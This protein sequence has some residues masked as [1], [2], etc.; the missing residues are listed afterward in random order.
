MKI[1]GEM[2]CKTG[3]ITPSPNSESP[4]CHKAEDSSMAEWE[5][6]VLNAL[7][8]C[9]TAMGLGK[10]LLPSWFKFP[11]PQGKESNKIHFKCPF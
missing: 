1:K 10:T 9:R 7:P 5:T 2:F 3:K 6:M 4:I 11:V 8:H